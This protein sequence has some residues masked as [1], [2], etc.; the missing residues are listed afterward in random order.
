M[1]APNTIDRAFV[2][3]WGRQ[4]LMLAEQNGSK[5]LPTVT[6]APVTGEAWTVERLGGTEAG[7]ITN[8]HA[9]IEQ[10]AIPHSR[11]WGYTNAYD[12]SVLIDGYDKVKTLLSFE[13]PYTKRVAD[14]LGR[15]MD[16]TIIG[17]LDATVREG[18][19][20]ENTSSFPG[21]QT[22]GTNSTTD[23]IS[24]ARLLD[25]KL[26]F[27]QADIDA[28]GLTW[29]CRPEDIRNLMADFQATSADYQNLKALV[30]GE[31]NTFLGMRIIWSNLIPLDNSRLVSFIYRS[32]GV[33]FGVAQEMN[34]T[35][36]RRIDLRTQPWQA[37]AWGAW[38]AVRTEDV[39]VVKIFSNATTPPHAVRTIA[40]T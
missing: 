29:V 5:L 18:K 35:I 10:T 25:A 3:Q 6:R 9:P 33:E 7:E 31:V 20:A 23:A 37:Y 21:S 11:R 16:R 39:R 24:V 34:V 15:A 22:V 14:A 8:R 32:D 12:R 36:D 13:S 38:G 27:D 40:V 28:G 17:S 2:I 1:A 30:A 19:N 4:V 26:K